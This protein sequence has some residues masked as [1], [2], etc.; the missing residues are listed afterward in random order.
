[1]PAHNYFARISTLLAGFEKVGIVLTPSDHQTHLY[2]W[3]VDG[4]AV[5]IGKKSDK[6]N[7]AAQ[8]KSWV[9]APSV[10][11]NYEVPFVRT[12]RRLKAEPVEFRIE[13][14]DLELLK[15]KL[16]EHEVSGFKHGFAE[17]ENKKTLSNA[18]IEAALIR[19][20]V[21]AGYVLANSTAAGQW[22]GA[23]K[24]PHLIGSLA[25]WAIQEH[26][27]NLFVGL[28]PASDNETSDVI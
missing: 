22:D 21:Q 4:C 5:Y 27:D 14:I 6:A 28:I 26:D 24:L 2:I 17:L 19:A 9:S 12:M 13:S 8:E 16:K 10:L 7:R 15:N 23:L 25:A 11:D 20:T 3:Q 1:M 18:D